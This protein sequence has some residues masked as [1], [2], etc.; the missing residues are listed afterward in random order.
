MATPRNGYIVLP[1]S[2]PE[3]PPFA[4]RPRLLHAF[5]LLV[6]HAAW[7]P[8]GARRKRGAVVHLERGQVAATIRELAAWWNCSRSNAERYL[9]E[10]AAEGFLQL[11]TARGTRSRGESPAKP[12]YR[13]TVITI[14]GYNQFQF[15]ARPSKDGIGLRSR[16]DAG[17]ELPLSLLALRES[18]RQD[19]TINL[20]HESSRSSE[21]QR[22]KPRHGATGRGMVWL[23]YGTQEWQIHADDY[24]NVRGAEKL[25]ETRIGGRGNWFRIRGEADKERRA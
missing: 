21:G 15:A 2:L 13:V 25:P 7:K 17:Q 19:N 1:R 16:N 23:D 10:L 12:S 3:N 24:R 9:G 20:R 22:S 5:V 11:S 18:V 8:E 4:E 6:I 14:C